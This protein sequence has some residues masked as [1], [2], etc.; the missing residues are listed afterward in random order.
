M[1]IMHV[2]VFILFCLGWAV[3]FSSA[4]GIIRSCLSVFALHLTLIL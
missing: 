4:N 3:E 2:S 1:G